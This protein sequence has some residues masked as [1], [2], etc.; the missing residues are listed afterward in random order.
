MLHTLKT[1]ERHREKM[2]NNESQLPEQELA[3]FNLIGYLDELDI[4]PFVLFQE[5]TASLEDKHIEVY[6]KLFDRGLEK[7]SRIGSANQQI[8]KN[9]KLEMFRASKVFVDDFKRFLSV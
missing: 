3:V 6:Y 2:N 5:V 1:K 7:W 9:R 8:D 4:D